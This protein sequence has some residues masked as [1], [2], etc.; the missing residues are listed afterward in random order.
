[1]NV[2]RYEVIHRKFVEYLYLAWVWLSWSER[3]AA[4]PRAWLSW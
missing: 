2:G 4:S 3:Q 1:M